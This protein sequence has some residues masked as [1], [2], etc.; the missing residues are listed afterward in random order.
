ME[1]TD[2]LA[3]LLDPKTKVN[4]RLAK[5]K[6]ERVFKLEAVRQVTWSRMSYLMDPKT[7][8]HYATTN[9]SSSN[10][11]NTIVSSGLIT[12][13]LHVGFHSTS[14]PVPTTLRMLDFGMSLQSINMLHIHSRKS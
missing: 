2:N 13:L 7:K 3:Y 4:T 14:V 1:I 10:C 6:F 9:A 12:N 11:L 5:K 8:I